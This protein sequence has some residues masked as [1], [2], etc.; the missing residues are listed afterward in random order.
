MTKYELY[1]I[2][3][4]FAMFQNYSNKWGSNIDKILDVS[5]ENISFFL[6]LA[7]RENI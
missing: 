4:D 2:W 6:K 1:E 7:K 3:E 5:K